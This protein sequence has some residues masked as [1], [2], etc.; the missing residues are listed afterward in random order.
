MEIESNNNFIYKKNK[1]FIAIV[2][3]DDLVVVDTGDALLITKRDQ[4]GKVGMVVDTLKEQ[5]K[6]ELL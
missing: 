6:T 1:K 3:V 4:T 5:N 2:G